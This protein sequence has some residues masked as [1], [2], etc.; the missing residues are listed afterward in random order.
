MLLV[1]L[2]GQ[3]AFAQEERIFFGSRSYPYQVNLGRSLPPKPSVQPYGNCHVEAA[4]VAAEAACYRLTGKYFSLSKSYLFQR[5]IVESLAISGNE[6]FLSSNG[7]GDFSEYDAGIPQKTMERIQNGSVLL[8]SEYTWNDFDEAVKAGLAIRKQ[9]WNSQDTRNPWMRFLFSPKIQPMDSHAA[10]K[11]MR[12]ALLNGM[13]QKLKEKVKGNLR[14]ATIGLSHIIFDQPK[15]PLNQCRFSQL[16][17]K[18][19]TVTP[20]RAVALITNGIPFACVGSV[21]D[22]P[23][24]PLHAML[25]AGYTFSKGYP[26]NLSFYVRDSRLSHQFDTGWNAAC[27]H[28]SVVYY[29]HEGP[30]VEYS[31]GL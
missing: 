30:I 26:S 18:T 25:Y 2:S 11:Q 9:Y 28:A 17:Q 4:A 29:P 6:W 16:I 22:D 15:H 10:E 3:F 12:E 5:H 8:E 21:S 19:F 1:C 27:H 7:R 20:E 13:N 31:I 24:L 14:V 23:N